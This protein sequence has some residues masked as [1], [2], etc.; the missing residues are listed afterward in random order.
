MIRE[1]LGELTHERR[2]V[3]PTEHYLDP[4]QAPREG[5][6]ATAIKNLVGAAMAASPDP[7][8]INLRARPELGTKESTT[9]IDPSFGMGAIS[10]SLLPKAVEAL[11]K[12]KG[13]AEKFMQAPKETR[14]FHGTPNSFDSFSHGK[15]GSTT[16]P[17]VVGRGFYFSSNP[18]G[19]GVYAMRPGGNIRPVELSAKAPLRLLDDLDDETIGRVSKAMQDLGLGNTE[20]HAYFTRPRDPRFSGHKNWD[21]L[22]EIDQAPDVVQNIVR[23]AGFDSIHHNPKNG[24]QTWVAF[25]PEQITP[26]FGKQKPTISASEDDF[27]RLLSM[28]GLSSL[29]RKSKK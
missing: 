5:Y 27:T 6:G 23:K 17:G 1:V 2:P 8:E 19:A 25:E 12:R 26:K 29:V 15:I 28:E 24:E 7:V 18:G 21:I 13:L 3:G 9:R 4:E 16:D 22:R 11:S 14:L 10:K 20:A